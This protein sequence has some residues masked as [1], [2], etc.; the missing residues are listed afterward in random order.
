MLFRSGPAGPTGPTGPMLTEENYVQPKEGFFKA[1]LTA[2]FDGTPTTLNLDFQ[3]VYS[4]SSTYTVISDTLTLISL[5]KYYSKD[6]EQ[7]QQG[8]I[9]MDF[10]V[11]NLISLENPRAESLNIMIKKISSTNKLLKYD[12]FDVVSSFSSVKSDYKFTNLKFDAATSTVTGNLTATLKDDK[13][14]KTQVSTITN[15]SFSS[16]LIQSV[17]NSRKAN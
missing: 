10:Y 4:N 3:G 6:G 14:S 17:S 2:N 12:F 11:K 8:Y 9:F 13:D 7:L 1:A 15:G 16:K 5:V